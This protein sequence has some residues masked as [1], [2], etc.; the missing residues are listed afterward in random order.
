VAVDAVCLHIPGS[1]SE[2]IFTAAATTAVDVPHATGISNVSGCCWH[3]CFCLRTCCSRR[4]SCGL[5]YLL[6]LDFLL[7]ST[8]L[9]QTF[10]PPFSS[11]TGVSNVWRRCCC[12]PCYCW[13]PCC[14]WL[15]AVL[16]AS[17]L[18][19]AFPLLPMLLL[20][21]CRPCYCLVLL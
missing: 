20:L 9:L 11:A 6:L 2:M 4:T 15:H 1:E 13:P 21:Q 18:L 17:L 10:F 19:I 7:L 14:G 3:S 16:L 12:H 8:S 5:A